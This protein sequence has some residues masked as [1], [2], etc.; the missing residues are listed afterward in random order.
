M[1]N[2]IPSSCHGASTKKVLKLEDHMTGSN[3]NVESKCFSSRRS[4]IHLEKDVLLVGSPSRNAKKA[5]R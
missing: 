3:D 5:I 2:T 1:E 4:D